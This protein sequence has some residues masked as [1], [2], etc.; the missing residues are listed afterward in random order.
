MALIRTMAKLVQ[1]GLDANAATNSLTL[2]IGIASLVG[3][4]IR[5]ATG[6]HTTHV[7]TLQSSVDNINWED[8]TGATVTGEGFKGEVTISSQFVRA[9]VTTPEG[10]ASTIDLIIQA[11]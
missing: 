5:G 7:V 10:G 6:A 4:Q 1:A 9:S 3:F 11:K 2:D 8:A